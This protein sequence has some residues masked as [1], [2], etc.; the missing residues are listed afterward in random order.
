MKKVIYIPKTNIIQLNKTLNSAFRGHIIYLLSEDDSIKETR[1]I[2]IV[3]DNMINMKDSVKKDEN[4]EANQKDVNQNNFGNDLDPSGS[5]LKNGQENSRDEERPNN[6]E[7]PKSNT[8]SDE[9]ENE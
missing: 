7:S 1:K 5:Q 9:K 2:N 3:S 8:D 4:F 6:H